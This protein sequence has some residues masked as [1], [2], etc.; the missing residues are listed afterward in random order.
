M[1]NSALAEK[2]E[3]DVKRLEVS[4]HGVSEKGV[5]LRVVAYV[6]GK[7]EKARAFRQEVTLAILG[8]SQDLGL[9]IMTD[10]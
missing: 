7:G 6:R 5:E 1:A 10:S 2:S 9:K 8:L 3:V 4:L